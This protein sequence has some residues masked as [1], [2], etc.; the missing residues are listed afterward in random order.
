MRKLKGIKKIF[1]F[2]ALL[3]MMFGV[4]LPAYATDLEFNRKGERINEVDDVPG[5]IARQ[6]SKS[7]LTAPDAN[8]TVSFTTDHDAMRYPMNR[9]FLD[10]A[11]VFCIEPMIPIAVREGNN[12][13]AVK[14]SGNDLRN[15]NYNLDL[16]RKINFIGMYYK[17]V[18]PKTEK[19][20]ALTQLAIWETNMQGLDG[21]KMTVF[22]S[23]DGTNPMA[24]VYKLI[25]DAMAYFNNGELQNLG[26]FKLIAGDS[27]LINLP[28]VYGTKVDGAPSASD[29]ANYEIVDGKLK[30]TAKQKVGQDVLDE[31]RF[32]IK[33]VLK[34]LMREPLKIYGKTGNRGGAQRLIDASGIDPINIKLKVTVEEENDITFYKYDEHTKE[35]IGGAKYNIINKEGKVVTTFITNEDEKGQKKDIKGE[36]IAKKLKFGETYKVKET[37]AP[38]GYKVEEKEFE[39]KMTGKKSKLQT[40]KLK[41]EAKTVYIAVTKVDSNDENKKLEGAEFTLFNAKDDTVFED[42][43]GKAIKTTN[44][45]GVA[46]FE[47]RFNRKLDLYVKET[48][49]PLGYR[50]NDEKFKI[51]I[52]KDYTFDAENP[53]KIKVNDEAIKAQ[54]VNTFIDGNMTIAVAVISFATIGIAAGVVLHK[55]RK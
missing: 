20:W 44:K 6:A 28:G 7:R 55:T 53:I 25:D 26:E 15:N 35:Y 38:Q 36:L 51:E 3:V 10:G 50:I 48:N 13:Y 11:E 33:D 39:F 8:Y 46:I 37:D 17:A 27:K 32:P 24:E 4:T 14:I 9:Y 41:E 42:V 45:D 30:I 34:Q 47:T 43:N 54:V 29:F 52:T 23:E 40:V 49:A 1:A 2:L 16:M 31:N 22:E 18:L 12:T 21:F 5:E 19:N